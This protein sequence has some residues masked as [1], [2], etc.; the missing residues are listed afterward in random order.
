MCGPYENFWARPAG[1]VAGVLFLLCL[2]FVEWGSQ[3]NLWTHKREEDK[4]FA[5]EWEI[6]ATAS[7]ASVV[8]ISQYTV[9]YEALLPCAESVVHGMLF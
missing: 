8:R 2:V 7:S 6:S 9:D 5:A 3:I 1:S 4:V